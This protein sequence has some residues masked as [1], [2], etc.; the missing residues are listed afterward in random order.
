MFVVEEWGFDEIYDFIRYGREKKLKNI[1][2]IKIAV[3]YWQRFQLFEKNGYPKV[4]LENGEVTGIIFPLFFT[5][6]KRLKIEEMVSFKKGYGTIMLEYVKQEG[7]EKGL[8]FIHFTA[9]YK[10]IDFYVKKYFFFWGIKGDGFN[11]YQP[12]MLEEQQKQWLERF[13]KNPKPFNEFNRKL[14][15]EKINKKPFKL[16]KI[17]PEIK[18][19]L[20]K[21]GLYYV[22][23]EKQIW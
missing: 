23:K 21:Q 12:L 14:I 2:R 11:V 1:N 4:F 19:R 10:S 6:T 17:I 9:N 20:I 5:R 15:I 3:G 22:E 8:D 18:E 13:K 16:Q 7:L